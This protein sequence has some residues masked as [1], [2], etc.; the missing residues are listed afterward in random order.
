MAK[1]CKDVSTRKDERLEPIITV[2]EYVES[3]SRL[4]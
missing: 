2:F 3:Y 1:T 4:D